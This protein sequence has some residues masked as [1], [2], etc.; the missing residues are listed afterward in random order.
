MSYRVLF[1][2]VKQYLDVPFCM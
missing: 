1:C 2:F